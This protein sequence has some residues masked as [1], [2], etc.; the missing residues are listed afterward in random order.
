MTKPI[1]QM[2]DEE[3]DAELRAAGGDPDEIGRRGE[4]LARR[5]LQKRREAVH[6]KQPRRPAELYCE[7]HGYYD[8][9]KPCPGCAG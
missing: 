8:G 2:T 3:V 6:E 4:A 9:R 7:V 1:D 5:L